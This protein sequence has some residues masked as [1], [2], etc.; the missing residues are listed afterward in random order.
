MKEFQLDSSLPRGCNASFIA[1]IPKKD[2]P[3]HLGEYRPISLVG[4]LHNIISK[5]L[6]S[7]FKG[8]IGSIV[9]DSQSVFVGSRNML[10]GV[11]IA[12]ETIDFVKRNKKPSI[13][14]KVDFEKAYDSISW[15]FLD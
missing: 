4:F 11:V 1:L 15:D 7:R 9:A 5:C 6:A 12:N 10:D 8:V 14:L 2:N 13:L 3:E